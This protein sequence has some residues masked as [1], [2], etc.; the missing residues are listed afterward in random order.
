[1][2]PTSL[3]PFA[4]PMDDMGVEALICYA[5]SQS[6]AWEAFAERL[7]ETY[8][9]HHKVAKKPTKKT[10]KTPPKP[11]VVE[12]TVEPIVEPEVV[13]PE[14]VEPTVAEPVIKAKPSKKGGRKKKVVE[15]I[16]EPVVEPIVEPV[17]EPE[18]VEPVVE[19]EVVEPVVGPVVEP[20]VGPEVVGKTMEEVYEWFNNHMR[21][22]GYAMKAFE[23]DRVE[24]DIAKFLPEV[25]GFSEE[26][27]ERFWNHVNKSVQTRQ[28][29]AHVGFLEDDVLKNITSD[30]I[31][32]ETKGRFPLLSEEEYRQII[33]ER[34]DYMRDTRKEYLEKDV[35]PTKPEKKKGG[36][37]KT[38]VTE[39]NDEK[40]KRGPT[41]YNLFIKAEIARI[42][43]QDPSVNHKAAMGMAAAAWK[44]RGK[45]SN[46]T[47]DLEIPIDETTLE[48]TLSA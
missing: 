28:L 6:A 20:V 43:E 37:K 44:S 2:N 38:E 13:E 42:R 45:P 31:Y 5:K 41:A 10:K 40:K 11:K 16:V 26:E 4:F 9:E 47:E 14:V 22:T 39:T 1:M 17:F 7:S 27:R 8:A 30:D 33:D 24:A 35:Q 29:E 21:L 19:P 46:E 48:N 18:V 25:D 32:Q 12:P 36:K 23:K 3:L 34:L 15:P